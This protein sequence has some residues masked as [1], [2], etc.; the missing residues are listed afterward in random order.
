MSSDQTVPSESAGQGARKKSAL[1]KRATGLAI[2]DPYIAGEQ[3]A[4]AERGDARVKFDVPGAERSRSP[5]PGAPEEP[6]TT[7]GAPEEPATTPGAPE[8]PATTPGAP[9]E[10]GRRAGSEGIV[11]PAKV[12]APRKRRSSPG[13]KTA[14]RGVGASDSGDGAAET[15][16]K[17]S[18]VAGQGKAER[19]QSDRKSAGLWGSRLT[20]YEFARL[21]ASRT[22]QLTDG[23]V[24]T[25]PD[26]A[27]P[28]ASPHR[29]AVAELELGVI[30][31]AVQREGPD[32]KAVTFRVDQLKIP[33]S[34]LTH[35]KA[36][37][38][39]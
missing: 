8:E 18:A 25:L 38:L 34:L 22:Q 26:G 21:V 39:L 6:A 4:K 17:A 2:G 35:H 31:L 29:V 32:G 27:S 19:L 12:A 28:G 10:D 15:P 3:A 30:P 37:Q 24:T 23:A 9:E 7:P 14:A 11:R 33:A 13:S 36:M 1:K 16:T 20:K 5:P